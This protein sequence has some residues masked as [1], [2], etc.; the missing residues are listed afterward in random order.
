M[1]VA[2]AELPE[3]SRRRAGGV[4][5]LRA[6]TN[7]GLEQIAF[8][9]VPSF[10]AFLLLGDAVVATVLQRGEFER[11]DTILVY[12][13][14]IGFSI[15]L[16]ASTGTRLFSSTFFALRDTKTPARFAITRVLAAA[17][18]G[19]LFMVQFEPIPSQGIDTRFFS[20]P[21]GYVDW[22][23]FTDLTID[24]RLL[25]AVGLAA[26]S[27]IAAWIEWNLMR[28]A[29]R[30]RIG[31]VGA[32]LAKVARMFAAA[33]L[34]AAVGWGVRILLGDLHPLPAGFLIFAAYGV[35]YFGAAAALKLR[36]AELVGARIAARFGGGRK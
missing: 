19:L 25:G 32:R 34:A 30:E 29:L 6:R 26:G 8:F 36:E 9:V 2:A 7:A 31:P 12:L 4:D 18:L 10:V 17:G 33:L 15:G 13:T 1:S 16:V 3:L 24:G 22:G 27:G 35:V 5:E 11:I 20:V 21:P 23:L 14:L 28:R